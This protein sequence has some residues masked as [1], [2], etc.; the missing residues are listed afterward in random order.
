MELVLAGLAQSCC[1]VYL[2][3]VLVI[4]STI[5]EHNHN[6]ERVLECVR[7]VG[8]RLKSKKCKF[9]QPFVL[10]LGHVVSEH[11]VKTD[12]QKVKAVQGYTVPRDVKAL[13]SFLGLASNY[14]RF[15]PAFS[16]SVGP[17]TT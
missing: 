1:L 11:G 7:K 12:P 2:D 5:E 14:R 6:L 8:L 13:R 4:G 9:G 17:G 16:S 3:D 10:Y 15:V